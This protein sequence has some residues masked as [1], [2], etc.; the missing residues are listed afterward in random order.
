MKSNNMNLTHQVTSLELSRRLKALGVKQESY[1]WWNYVVSSSCE[2]NDD[3]ATRR[4]GWQL[5]SAHW[6]DAVKAQF[7]SAYTVAE[8]GNLL[9]REIEYQAS[10]KEKS[11][12]DGYRPMFLKCGKTIMD[13]GW[14]VMYSDPHPANEVPVHSTHADTEADARG[15]M[16]AYLLENSLI[17]L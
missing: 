16:L 2:G 6:E 7:C 10:S 3:F 17:K 5:M 15:L 1:F 8:L 13:N 9:P 12:Y 11:G 4:E 14:Y